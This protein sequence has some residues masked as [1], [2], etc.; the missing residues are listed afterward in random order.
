MRSRPVH[1]RGAGAEVAYGADRS[2]DDSTA[3]GYSSALGVGAIALA[4]RHQCR[5][6]FRSATASASGFQSSAFGSRH[7]GNGRQQRRDGG[8]ALTPT[9]H[10]LL[11]DRAATS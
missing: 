2:L 9:A 3:V 11:T 7:A 1:Q 8:V 6:R 5:L 4:G 10:A